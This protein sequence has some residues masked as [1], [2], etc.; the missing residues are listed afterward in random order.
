MKHVSVGSVILMLLGAVLATGG[1][2]RTSNMGTAIQ[3]HEMNKQ[4]FGAA[5][6]GPAPQYFDGTTLVMFGF[7]IVFFV[8]AGI[9]I[10]NRRR[11]ALEQS[12]REF[13]A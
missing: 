1:I 7:A 6:A 4:M 3:L 10:S 5:S 11:A 9:V 8:L 13:R 12:K 2:V